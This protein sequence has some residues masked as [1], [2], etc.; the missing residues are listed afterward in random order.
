VARAA[1]P[2]RDSYPSM[3]AGIASPFPGVA[4]AGRRPIGEGFL[5][6][7]AVALQGVVGCVIPLVALAIIRS[8]RISP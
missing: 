2:A 5:G 8:G 4:I 6:L 1:V 3:T 7:T